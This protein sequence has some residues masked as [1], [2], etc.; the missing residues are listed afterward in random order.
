[1]EQIRELVKRIKMKIRAKGCEEMRGGIVG[2]KRELRNRRKREGEE[3][4][5]L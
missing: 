5:G 4:R 3:Y 2:E 1:M